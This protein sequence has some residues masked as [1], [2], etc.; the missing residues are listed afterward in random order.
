MQMGIYYDQT[1]CTGCYTCVVACKD[2]HDVPAGPASWR[3]IETTEEGTYP[4]VFVSFMAYSCFHCESPA[5][6]PACPAG[7]ITKRADDGIVVVDREKCLGKDRC[8]LCLQACVYKAP[9]FGAE[10]NAK[11]QKCDLCLDRLQEGKKPIC[12]AGCPTRA[13]DAGPLD[14]LRSQY[15]N[16]TQGYAFK[17]SAELKPAVIFKPKPKRSLVGGAK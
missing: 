14:E 11:M 7:A 12:V 6:V 8:D 15:G 17:Y 9:Q 10:Q 4:D 3:R 1:R 2:W 13:L 5:C 16:S